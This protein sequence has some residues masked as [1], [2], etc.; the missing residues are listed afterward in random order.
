MS[1][2]G[3]G[4]GKSVSGSETEQKRVEDNPFYTTSI[5]TKPL[6]GVIVILE[7][8]KSG[9]RTSGKEIK[10]MNTVMNQD[11]LNRERY[12]ALSRSQGFAF[13][14]P[15]KIM[16]ERCCVGTGPIES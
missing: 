16:R 3:E 14:H 6:K 9:C 7:K 2:C 1:I 15:N 10:M 11:Y 4:E 5:M 13:M 8:K 12:E